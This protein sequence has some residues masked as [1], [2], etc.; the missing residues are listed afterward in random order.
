MSL[1]VSETVER[2]LDDIWLYIATESASVDIADRVI[3]SITLK[4]L[5]LT[6]FPLMGRRRNDL[7]RG[8]RSVPVGSYLIIYRVDDKDVRILHVM[9]G[10][11]DISTFIS[12]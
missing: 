8:L 9:H 4:F 7:R 12:Q 11:R 6:R 1:I 2:E 10:R 3:D 5:E